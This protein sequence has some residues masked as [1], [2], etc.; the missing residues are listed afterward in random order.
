MDT[1]VDGI[2]KIVVKSGLARIELMRFKELATDAE[3]EE[4]EI[5][6]R[7]AMSLDTLLKFH[8]GL[9]AVMEQLEAKGVLQKRSQGTSTN[10]ASKKVN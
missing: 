4:L 3:A 5:S 8:R 9:S 10:K 7:L 1:V 6:S 2:G